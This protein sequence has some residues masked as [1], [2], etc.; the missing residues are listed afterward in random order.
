[1][2]NLQPN[3][4]WLHPLCVVHYW[5]WTRALLR[6]LGRPP[7][8]AAVCI[9]DWSGTDRGVGGGGPS[10]LLFLSMS[11][12]YAFIHR[13][14]SLLCV[15][16]TLLQ[17]CWWWS[18]SVNT[19]RLTSVLHAAMTLR[20]LQANRTTSGGSEPPTFKKKTYFIFIKTYK[21]LTFSKKSFY[22]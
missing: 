1:M 6:A 12:V 7:L 2:L 9:W 20:Q 8:E 14:F 11:S 18:P 5:E 3:P 13:F 17:T 22:S 19:P 15:T 21:T 10:S 16:T 4:K